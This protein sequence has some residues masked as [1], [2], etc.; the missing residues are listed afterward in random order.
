[1]IALC[2]AFGSACKTQRPCHVEYE[3]TQAWTGGFI[4]NV[5]IYNEGE[6]D[7][8]LENG[9]HF[10]FEVPERQEIVELWDGIIQEYASGF[11]VKNVG[12]N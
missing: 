4:A 3:V 7:L 5:E 1:M 12:W 11:R 6:R 10:A 2:F 8:D 9:W